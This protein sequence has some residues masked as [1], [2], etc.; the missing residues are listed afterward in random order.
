MK[1]SRQIGHGPQDPRNNVAVISLG[2]LL[3]FVYPGL[4]VRNANEDSHKSTR[5]SLVSLAKGPAK[6]QPQKTDVLQTPLFKSDII[7]PP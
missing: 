1:R 3:G 6:G 7:P 4:S 2:F 5:K